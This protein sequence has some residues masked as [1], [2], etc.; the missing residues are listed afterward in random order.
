MSHIRHGRPFRPEHLIGLGLALLGACSQTP[1]K[2]A[3]QLVVIADPQGAKFT[4]Q[5]V[6]SATP[7]PSDFAGT[8]LATNADLALPPADDLQQETLQAVARDAD[9]YRVADSI[10][11]EDADRLTAGS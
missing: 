6:L 8:A 3:E 11:S 5:S 7:S 10:L 1:E 4:A 2:K 9:P